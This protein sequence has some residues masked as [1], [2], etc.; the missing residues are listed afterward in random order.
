VA[1]L[2]ALKLVTCRSSGGIG[3]RG[4]R[5]LLLQGLSGASAAVG[6][7]LL[8]VGELRLKR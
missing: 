4:P 2:H 1:H 6:K 5:L 7:P 8:R 3:S